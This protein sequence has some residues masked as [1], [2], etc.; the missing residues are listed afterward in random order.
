[1]KASANPFRSS[2]VDQL[3]YALPADTL[4]ALVDHALSESCSCL[5]GPKGTGKT[6]LLEDLDPHLQQR[7]RETHWIR[8]TLESTQADRAAAIAEIHSLGPQH[9]CLFDG[10]EV[11]S[12]W[13]WRRACRTARSN[14]FTL[15]AT[16]HRKRSVPI[17]R[18]TQAD[19]PLMEQFVRQ[20]AGKHYSDQLLEHAQQAFQANHGN[21]REVFRACYLA[22]AQ[23]NSQ[24]AEK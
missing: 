3:R 10:A 21:M 7:G 22:L 12:F 19:W 14:G 6:T 16:L 20:L 23:E 9:A 5:L 8:L 15:I 13:Q 11:L 4:E 17:L 18:H 1:M 24:K 2:C